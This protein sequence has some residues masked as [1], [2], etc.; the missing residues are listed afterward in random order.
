RGWAAKAVTAIS[1]LAMVYFALYPFGVRPHMPMA[2]YLYR[3]WQGT[4]YSFAAPFQSYPIFRPSGFKTERLQ[5]TAELD[6]RLAGGPVLLMAQT[7]VPPALPSGT[8]A[9]VMYSEFPLARFGLGQVGA[10]YIRG[11]TDFAARHGFLKLLPLTW[12]TLY[13]V[14]RSATIRS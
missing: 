4:V 11:Y 5:S 8:R 2:R 9:T 13:R 14:E 7:P 3:H 6:A 1:L 12:Y 10:D